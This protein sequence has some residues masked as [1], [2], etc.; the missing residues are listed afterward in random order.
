MKSGYIAPKTTSASGCFVLLE[1]S[2]FSSSFILYCT[3]NSPSD[4]PLTVSQ[5]RCEYILRYVFRKGARKPF[6]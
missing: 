2:G 5:G 6:A 1:V 4:T 3:Y